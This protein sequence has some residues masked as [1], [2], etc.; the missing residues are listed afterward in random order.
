LKGHTLGEGRSKVGGA[1][2]RHDGYYEG[3]TG[4]SAL[5][6]RKANDPTDPERM[7]N[8]RDRDSIGNGTQWGLALLIKDGI[9]KERTPEC[10]MHGRLGWGDFG[11][12]GGLKGKKNWGK[13]QAV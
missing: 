5:T 1:L 8:S 4:V 3:E 12:G 7:R 13:I 11:G 9:K 10:T 2:F 6:V